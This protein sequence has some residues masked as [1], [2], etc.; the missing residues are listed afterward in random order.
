MNISDPT[1]ESDT[2]WHRLDARAKLAA[3]ALWSVGVACMQS[4]DALG[5]AVIL[6]VLVLL[7]ARLSAGVVI[8]RLAVVNVFIVAMWLILPWRITVGDAWFSAGGEQV[9]GWIAYHPAGVTLALRLTLRTN[10]IVMVLLALLSTSSLI[11][12]ARGLR[13]LCLPEK[14]V[15]ILL[16]AVR[17]VVVIDDELQRMWAA[18]RM[19]AFAPAASLHAY[20]TYANLLGLLLVRSHNRASRIRDAMLVRGFD[21]HLPELQDKRMPQA[22]WALVVVTS[23]VL[24]VMGWLE[25]RA[26]VN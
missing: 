3:V 23:L 21:G 22:G 17:Y 25:W 8:R 13:R 10:A 12:T 14:L 26:A 19:R 4:V 7:S 5:L 6:A 20:R 24:C 9:D 16:F 11:S 18:V 15:L 2:L 1:S